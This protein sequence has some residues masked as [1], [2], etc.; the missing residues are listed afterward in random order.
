MIC[1]ENEQLRSK[2]INDKALEQV[3]HISNW[4]NEISYAFSNILHSKFRKFEWIF[5]R[6]LGH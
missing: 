3:S 5:K 2:V 4:G 6:Q 1:T